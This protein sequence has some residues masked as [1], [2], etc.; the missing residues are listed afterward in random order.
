[1]LVGLVAAAS[2]A[3]VGFAEVVLA[4]ADSARHSSAAAF[5]EPVSAVGS[6]ALA[7]SAFDLVW[8]FAASASSP[9]GALLSRL[10]RLASG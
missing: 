1:M 8:A 4:V 9:E 7:A 2:G 5:G 3:V 6:W 10:C